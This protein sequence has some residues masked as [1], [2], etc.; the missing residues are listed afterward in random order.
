ML[1]VRSNALWA[2]GVSAAAGSFGLVFTIPPCVVPAPLACR[3]AIVFERFALRRRRAGS[4]R[5]GARRGRRGELEQEAPEGGDGA[6]SNGRGGAGEDDGAREH[7]AVREGDEDAAGDG[8]EPVLAVG[9]PELFSEL[10]RPAPARDRLIVGDLVTFF[11][12]FRCVFQQHYSVRYLYSTMY[13]IPTSFPIEMA[14]L[15]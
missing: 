4:Q 7:D 15:Q 9:A 8:G 2:D 13:F 14:I 10:H 12:V 11:F 6:A 1:C 5:L 3:V